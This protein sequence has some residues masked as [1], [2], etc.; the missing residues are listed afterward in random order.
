MIFGVNWSYLY[1]YL[2]YFREE[3]AP[4]KADKII[5]KASKKDSSYPRFGSY[6]VEKTNS[7]GNIINYK[8]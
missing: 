5:Q 3:V 2:S 1:S 7:T 8:I 6:R 4:V